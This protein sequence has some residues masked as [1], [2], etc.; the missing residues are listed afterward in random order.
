M[1]VGIALLSSELPLE[2]MERHRLEQRLHERGGEREVRF[3]YRQAE[4]RLP[5]WHEGL[6]K[7]VRWGSRRTESRRLPPTGW[8]WQAT[9]EAGG[10]APFAAEPVDIP[11]NFALENGVWYRVRQGIRGLLVQDEH[12]LPAVYM[13]CEPATRYYRIMTRS[14][15]MPTLIAEII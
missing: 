14:E 7:I 5:V 1:C 6:L 10:W 11:A 15:R 8:T 12:G 9:V 3:L 2:L 4:R 13:L